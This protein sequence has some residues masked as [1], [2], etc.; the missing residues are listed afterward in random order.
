MTLVFIDYGLAVML[1]VLTLTTLFSAQIDRAIMSFVGAGLVASLIWARLSAPD[2]AI[3]EAAIGAGVTGALLLATWHRLDKPEAPIEPASLLVGI[4]VTVVILVA[5]ALLVMTMTT[6]SGLGALVQDKLP[7]SDVGNPVTGVLLNFR[8][9]DTLMEIG[10]LLVTL[11]AVK[12]LN[13]NIAPAA[14]APG[15]VLDSLVRVAVPLAVVFGGYVLWAGADTPGGAFQAGAIWSGAGLLLYLSGNLPRLPLL[16]SF[17]P[18]IGLVTF[19]TAALVTYALTGV[20][21]Q[22]ALWPAGL[23][24][25][26]IEVFA[27]LSIAATLFLLV[28]PDTLEGK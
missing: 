28:V 15:P 24:I 7:L 14:A 27:A 13:L 21:L 20:V 5:A 12:S 9:F 17:W 3:A 4:T 18:T 22:Y 26:V 23:W 2:I 10:V 16:H 25:V 11:V 19:T 6:T 8:S 1:A